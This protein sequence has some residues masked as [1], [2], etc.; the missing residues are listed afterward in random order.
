MV[1]RKP[2]GCPG[3]LCILY[4]SGP[5]FEMSSLQ[6]SS[7]S[8]LLK[9]FCSFSFDISQQD[10]DM[11]FGLEPGCPSALSTGLLDFLF[12]TRSISR[13]PVKPCKTSLASWL[14]EREPTLTFILLTFD[15]GKFDLF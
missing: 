3:L 10:S 2:Q 8:T 9:G 14:W 7:L 12:Q 6:R 13:V 15:P 5:C 11:E 1:K 4:I